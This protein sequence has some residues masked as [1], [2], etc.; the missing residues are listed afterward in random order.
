M[1]LRREMHN[2]FGRGSRRPTLPVVQFGTKGCDGQMRVVANSSHLA[3]V[4]TFEPRYLNEGPKKDTIGTK[5]TPCR[6]A[7]THHWVT[8]IT[9]ARPAIIVFFLCLFDGRFLS[10]F[11]DQT[12][13]PKRKRRLW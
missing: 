5:G 8:A 2:C 7:A 4:S 1:R 12:L 9:A 13:S 11:Q 10:R 6:L 3:P